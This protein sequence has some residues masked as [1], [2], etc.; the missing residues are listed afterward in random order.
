MDSECYQC[1]NL[2]K[3]F[4]FMQCKFCNLAVHIKC[5][6]LKRS[7]MDF[8]NERKNVLWVCD[9]CIDEL[10][11]LKENRPIT[12]NE[13]VTGVS[14]AIKESLA[15][16]KTDLQVTRA[17]TESIAGKMPSKGNS[18]ANSART[19]WPSIKRTR[20]AAKET[21]KTR[22]DVKLTIGT[23]SVDKD[24]LTVETVAK[25]P[26]KFWL[27]LSRI[28]RHVTE[29]DISQLVKNCLQTEDSIE[30]RK[31]VRKGADLAQFA[32]ISFKVGVDV[33]LK[34]TALDPTVWP[35]G[36]YFREFENVSNER[37]FWGPAK[38]PRIDDGIQLVTGTPMVVSSSP[39]R[40]TPLQ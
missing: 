32:F 6:G 9:K 21:P 1:S 29:A 22:P 18:S 4:E 31:L 16:L 12:C 39:D 7:N 25:P 14:E 17:L 10:E 36:V 38:I 2:I 3:S 19:A 30:V 11:I 26:E 15:N 13:I 20:E 40:S 27:Y 24:D 23:K 34:N 35:K 5:V 37:D 8:V 28:A 33:K